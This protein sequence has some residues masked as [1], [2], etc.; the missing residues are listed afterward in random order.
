MEEWL[1]HSKN[2]I[3]ATGSLKRWLNDTEQELTNDD[4]YH[5][6]S[7]TVRSLMDALDVRSPL[8]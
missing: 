3:A 4:K 2:F 7:N 6:D 5:G 1:S 8:N